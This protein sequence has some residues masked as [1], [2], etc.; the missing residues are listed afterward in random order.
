MIKNHLHLVNKSRETLLP[1]LDE[2]AK[3]VKQG[4]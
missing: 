4:I 1:G 2:A 3:A